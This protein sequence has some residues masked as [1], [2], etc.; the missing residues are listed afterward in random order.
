M[1]E[2]VCFHKEY[3]NPTARGSIWTMCNSVT[4]YSCPVI[5]IEVNC[6]HSFT[7]HPIAQQSILL[8]YPLGYNWWLCMSSTGQQWHS[9]LRHCATRQSVPGLI[10]NLIPSFH[11]QY[12]W[13]QLSLHEK[14]VPQNFLGGKAWPVNR[15]DNSAVLVVPNVRVKMGAQHS[16]LPLSLHDLLWDSFTCMS[17]NRIWL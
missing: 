7:C 11:I 4:P 12:P 14:W 5:K 9:W 3:V 13:G 8:P 2:Q 6:A 1:L 10:P 15:D 17:C 16:I